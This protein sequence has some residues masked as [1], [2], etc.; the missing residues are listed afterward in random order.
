[1][2]NVEL[3]ARLPNPET[4]RR[5]LRAL[6]ARHAGTLR[7]TDTYFQVPRGRLKLR[8]MDGRRVELIAYERPDDR[9][10]RVSNYDIAP[11]EGDAAL[12]KQALARA[13][14]VRVVV[15]KERDL[16]LLRSTRVHL[17]EVA[18][19]GAFVEL[20]TVAGD[21]G[22][23]EAYGEFEEV[24]AALELMSFAA[25]AGSYADLLEARRP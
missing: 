13:L 20:E 19:L 5:R 9:R 10:E 6:G 24:I 8:E 15:R 14:G 18:G 12:L 3:K 22:L 11:I 7:Q 1:M 16:W 2:V 21:I 23:A 25:I 4:L 17:D